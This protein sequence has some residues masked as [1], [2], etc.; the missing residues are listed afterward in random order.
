MRGHQPILDM[1]REGY[2]PNSAVFVSD[3]DCVLEAWSARNWH[4]VANNTHPT[5][6]I[7]LTDALE[8]LDFRFAVG[9]HVSLM[10]QRGEERAKRLFAA[11]RRVEPCV[12]ACAMGNEIWI[13]KK[14][15]G[16]NGK[17]IRA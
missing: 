10:C 9:L 11:I 12:L 16:G 1:R 7:E 17:R 14:E 5:V 4:G 13:F 2:V 3:T 6:L 15:E 8:Q